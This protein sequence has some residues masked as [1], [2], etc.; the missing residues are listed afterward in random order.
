MRTG[1]DN[2]GYTNEKSIE[3]AENEYAD[4]VFDAGNAYADD[5]G[6]GGIVKYL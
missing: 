1:G 3:H 5:S 2:C 6:K 4:S